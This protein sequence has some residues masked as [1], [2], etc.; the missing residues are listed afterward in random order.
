M[1]FDRVHIFV[2]MLH[3]KRYVASSRTQT[4]GMQAF[5]CLRY[6]M[7]TLA[8][9]V[10][11]QFQYVQ[12][13]LYVQAKTSLEAL[14]LNMDDDSGHTRQAQA[15][16]LLSMYELKR[17]SFRK[18]WISAGRAFR[19]IQLMKLHEIDMPD[20]MNDAHDNVD[21]KNSQLTWVEVEER[22]KTFWI[23]Y[24]LDRLVNLQ[25]RFPFTISDHAVSSVPSSEKSYRL[26][27]SHRS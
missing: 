16:L 3:H 2:P 7:W 4:S 23:A 12:D 19:F 22:R 24:C 8:A 5:D 25:N 26:M 1:F 10:C 18:G 27:S 14:E 11:S 17:V 13:A 6:A 9:S 15:W 20:G 21:V